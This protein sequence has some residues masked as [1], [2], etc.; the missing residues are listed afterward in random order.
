MGKLGQPIRVAITGSSMSPSINITIKLIGKDRV[1]KRL[2]KA[3]SIVK[4]RAESN[5]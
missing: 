4:K 5:N 3:I 1:L 2:E